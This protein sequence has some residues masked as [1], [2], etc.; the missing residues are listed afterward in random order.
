VVAQPAA[1]MRGGTKL[2]PRV[3]IFTRG[4]ISPVSRSRT[5]TDLGHRR[6]G[7]G[8]DRDEPRLRATVIRSPIDGYVKPAK[9]ERL[10]GADHE[11]GLDVRELELLP[12]L[13]ADD[14]LVHEDVVED[15]T[16]RVSRVRARHRRLDRLRDRDAERSGW[17]GSRAKIFF[18][19]FV[20]SLG[21]GMTSARRGA[22]C[23]CGTASGR[24]RRGP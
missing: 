15:R 8:F 16:Q 22:S 7:G 11:I 4:V 21:L 10:H 24:T 18:P 9:F 13:E 6:H 20:R 5:R 17:F 14:R 3:C 1:W 23:A 12:R 19:T 2:C